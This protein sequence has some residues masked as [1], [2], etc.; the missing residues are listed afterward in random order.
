MNKYLDSLIVLITGS[1]CLTL[2][3]MTM[4][5]FNTV[6]IDKYSLTLIYSIPGIFT[7]CVAL[8]IYCILIY[9]NDKPQ[10]KTKA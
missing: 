7:V 8:T 5:I 2:I 4:R 1:I 3:V 6:A 10:T 9:Q